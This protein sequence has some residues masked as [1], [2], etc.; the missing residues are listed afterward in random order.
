MHILDILKTL[1][2]TTIVGYLL[3]K[4]GLFGGADIKMLMAL[5][6]LY[7]LNSYV[8]I[9]VLLLSLIISFPLLLLILYKNK[10]EEHEIVHI[11]FIP[12]ISISF[13]LV[14]YLYYLNLEIILLRID[15]FSTLLHFVFS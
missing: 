13:F 15:F 12:I 11:P 8:M 3:F 7:P 14:L 9:L 4:I 1:S 6:I 5:S 10:I 2:V